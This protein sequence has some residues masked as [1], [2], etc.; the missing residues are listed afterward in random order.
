MVSHNAFRLPETTPLN[1]FGKILTVY[2]LESQPKNFI[3][4]ML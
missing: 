3:M 1:E 2:V 4:E